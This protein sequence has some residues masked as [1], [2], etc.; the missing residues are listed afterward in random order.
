MK[1]RMTIGSFQLTLLICSFLAISSQAS[2][3]M[4]LT[5]AAKQDAWLSY[6]VPIVYGCG[7]G[8]FFYKLVQKY[9][10]QN[11]YEIANALCGKFV[12][13]V[14][15][16]LFIL[17]FIVD[18]SAQTRLFT[19]FFSSSILLRTPPELIIMIITLLIIYYSTGTMEHLVRTNVVF[20]MCYTIVLMFLPVILMNEIDLR[21]L[22][23]VLSSG[24]VPPLKSSIISVASFG[25]ILAIGAF[26]HHVK[27]PREIYMAMKLGVV[28]SSFLLTLWNFC[29]VS[30]VSPVFVS[31]LIFTGWILVQQIH[32]TD[33]LDRVDLLVFSL[34]MPLILIKHSVLFF[35]ILTGLASYTKKRRI[36]GNLMVG[37]LVMMFST[38]AFDDTDEVIL[39]NNYG[40]IPL[41]LMIH[42][43]FFGCLGVGIAIS[44]WTGRTSTIPDAKTRLYSGPARAM[45]IGCGASIAFG[46]YFGS[47]LG[48]YG[49]ISAGL[50]IMFL[51]LCV[52]FTLLQYRK[53]IINKG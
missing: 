52:Y 34:F 51:L 6:F 44:K 32:V 48:W 24:I 21:K 45:L 15:N 12:G 30:V 1:D 3:P 38:V 31:R 33:F 29:L 27:G 18:L 5:G 4:A 11:M 46:A 26:L 50:F 47:K 42:I 14:L 8:M 10:G 25:D 17:Y 40:M 20:I 7:V 23:P 13:G 19:D 16:A 9:P 53:T 35:A 43:V 2:L 28:V 37:L 36:F 39:F 22:M 41:T 49:I